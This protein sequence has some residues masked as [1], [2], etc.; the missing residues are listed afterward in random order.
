MQKPHTIRHQ[1]GGNLN[2]IQQQGCREVRMRRMQ[3]REIHFRVGE[4][5]E[6]VT[7]DDIFLAVIT[8]RPHRDVG[9]TSIIRQSSLGDL[10]LTDTEEKTTDRRPVLQSQRGVIHDRSNLNHNTKR[11]QDIAQTGGRQHAEHRAVREPG[12]IGVRQG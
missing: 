6:I 10:S 12:K 2:I 8:T 1:P 11:F 5:I 9:N 3:R 4:L 7:S